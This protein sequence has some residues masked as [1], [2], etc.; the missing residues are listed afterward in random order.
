M[1]RWYFQ[2]L[3]RW[4]IPALLFLVALCALVIE[5]KASGGGL[6]FP[7]DDAYRSLAVA[8]TLV[9]Q[10]VYGLGDRPAM[11]AV[12]DALWYVSVAIT[13]LCTGSYTTAA[14]LLG[15]I[16]GLVTLVI[17]IR[18][19]RLLFPFPPFIMYTAVLL[20]VASGL[21]ISSID[22]TSQAL[23][24]FLVSALILLH[25]EG[26][27]ERK[28]PLPLIM[29][30]LVGLLVWIRIEFALLW[31]VLVIHGM[32]VCRGRSDK[33]SA[34]AFTITRGLTGMML[35][36]LFLFPLLAWNLHVLDVPWPQSID[37]PMTMDAWTSPAD[38]FHQYL[39]LVK[40]GIRGA[41]THL[42]SIPFLSGRFERW[43]TWFGVLFIA[44]ISFGREEERSI[45]VFLFLLLL[46]PLFYGLIYPFSGWAPADEI[47]STFG[48][49]CVLAAAFGI[50]RVPFLIENLYRKW[51]EGLPAATGFNVWWIAMGSILM[52]VSLVRAGSLI[53]GRMARITVQKSL[54]ENVAKEVGSLE[55]VA[56][57]LPGW[58]VYANNLSVIDLTGES[59]PEILACL[60]RD[61]D[62]FDEEEL[63]QYLQEMK[64]A[65][66]VI[67]SPDYDMVFDVLRCRPLGVEKEKPSARPRVYAVTLSGVP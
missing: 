32:F 54:R 44:G 10:Q 21:L 19:T 39:G 48:P 64:A 53:H 11:P 42:H 2:R 31:I 50:F 28:L 35:L 29:A 38:A 66:L 58:L 36:A 3:F 26:L 25:L 4:L 8:R 52:V 18:I 62:G 40:V 63:K 34:T 5:Q 30:V 57:D 43:L 16:F 45:S 17:Y 23:A 49:F 27:S 60:E 14:Y 7:K 41:Y 22:G 46:T 65:S 47:F 12:R 24:T 56:T 67:W 55:P 61:G 37:A 6:D 33:E 15:A 20:I 59:T 9:V 51:K 13:G 1:H